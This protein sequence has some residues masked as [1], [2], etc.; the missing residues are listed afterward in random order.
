MVPENSEIPEQSPETDSDAQP[1]QAEPELADDANHPDDPLDATADNRKPA[2]STSPSNPEAS[3]ESE[4]ASDGS[5]ITDR[6]AA[7]REAKAAPIKTIEEFLRFAY[8]QGGA[9]RLSIP[10][11][12]YQEMLRSLDTDVPHPDPLRA[13]VAELSD[14]DPIL[15]VPVR[16]LI[17]T[18]Q[19]A[20]SHRLTK[21]VLDYISI[22]LR[23]HAALRRNEIQ[24]LLDGESSDL[25]A[26]L[27]ALRESVR[28]LPEEAFA[29]GAT[30]GNLRRK[31]QVNATISLSLWF[32][33]ANKVPEG[34][35]VN[36]LDRHVWRDELAESGLKRPRAA[37]LESKTPE[38]LGWL[39]REFR[40]RVDDATRAAEDAERV[41]ER[42][43]A[44]EVELED[45]LTRSLKDAKELSSEITRLQSVIA[46]LSAEL[47]DQ[48][49][50]RSV[51]KTHH[52]DDYKG[53][54]A[55]VL[56]S[57]DK[58]SELLRSALHALRNE[59]YQVADEYVERS[60]DAIDSE[61]ERLREQGA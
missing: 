26:A 52:A 37:L 50:Q 11:S 40:H 45:Q 17:A 22:G 38:V 18:D 31:L 55:R 58:Q 1:A 21:R 49:R 60:M 57:L 54:R 13:L 33:I 51:D 61:R 28:S 56:R 43:R 32:A 3:A 41:A 42:A 2:G 39:A 4:A 23:R 29:H 35:F 5:S 47:V 8:S 19:A 25:D 16:V 59:R 34:E 53:L 9:K 15:A 36:T 10:A 24:R 30:K 12:S 20:P 7:A 44:R 6:T 14:A 46:A 27:S 48:Q